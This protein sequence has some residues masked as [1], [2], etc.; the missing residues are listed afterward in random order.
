MRMNVQAF[1]FVLLGGAQ[2]DQE[3]GD[4]QA[5]NATTGVQIILSRTVIPRMDDMSPTIASPRLRWWPTRGFVLQRWI[6]VPDSRLRS[7]MKIVDGA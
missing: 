2:V 7:A 3:I 4:L 6:A 5:T 1:A